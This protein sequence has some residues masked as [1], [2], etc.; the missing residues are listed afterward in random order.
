M[1]N[2]KPNSRPTKL[3]TAEIFVV[4]DYLRSN[5]KALQDERPAWD[6]VAARI[7]GANPKSL[8]ALNGNNVRAVAKDLGLAWM[9][10]TVPHSK[11]GSGKMRRELDEAIATLRVVTLELL[12]IRRAVGITDPLSPELQAIAERFERVEAEGGEV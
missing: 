4:G 9:P 7:L 12:E 3:N 11:G 10:K 2:G 1:Q 6:V 5:A 8:R